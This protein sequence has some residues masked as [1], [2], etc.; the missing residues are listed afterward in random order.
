MP[1]TSIFS[2][3]HNVFHFEKKMTDILTTFELS[4][5]KALNLMEAK[6]I[7]VW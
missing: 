7:V 2:F 1:V 5:A 3:S 6:N 4:S